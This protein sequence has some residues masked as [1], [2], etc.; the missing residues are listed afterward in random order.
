MIT[1]VCQSSSFAASLPAMARRW[2]S[3]PFIGGCT[4]NLKRLF[5]RRSASNASYQAIEL[6]EARYHFNQR[7]NY[8][9]MLIV[10][11]ESSL[12]L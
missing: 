7:T 6:G 1:V 5:P 10:A 9:G 11:S 4:L 8:G 3:R 2:V 12:R